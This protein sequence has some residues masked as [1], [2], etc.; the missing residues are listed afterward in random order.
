MAVI[1]IGPLTHLEKR[2]VLDY[3]V[4][5]ARR[6]VELMRELLLSLKG[7]TEDEQVVWDLLLDEVRSR[8]NIVA[9]RKALG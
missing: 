9:E 5:R 7:R 8:N 2:V 3:R 4:A 1:E 6:R